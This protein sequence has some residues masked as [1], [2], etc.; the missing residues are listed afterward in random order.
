MVIKKKLFPILKKILVRYLSNECECIIVI[1]VFNI[2]DQVEP[3]AVFTKFCD[4]ITI[5]SR[6]WEVADL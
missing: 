5:G 6:H 1:D 4:K 3:V 2:I